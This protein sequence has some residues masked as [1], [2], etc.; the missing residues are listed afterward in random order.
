MDEFPLK[1]NKFKLMQADVHSLPFE[2]DHFDTVVDT[3]TMNSY[4]DHDTA[5]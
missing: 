2:D 3:F 4:F 5:I 1:K